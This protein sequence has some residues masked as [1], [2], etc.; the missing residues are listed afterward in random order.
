[1]EARLG[2]YTKRGGLLLILALVLLLRLPFLNQ[3]IQ[4]DD[5]IYRTEAEHAQ[6]DPL[7]PNDV[8]YVFLGDVVDLRGHSHPPLNAWV[9]AAL[10]AV[11]GDIREVPFHAGYIVFSLIAA[12]AMWSLAKRYSPEPLWATL[13]FCA[14]PAFVINGNSLESDLPFLA[15]WMSAVALFTAGRFGW[16]AVAMAAAAM[17]AY[18]AVFLIPILA[19]WTWLFR[20]RD[21]RAWLTLAAPL[22]TIAAWQ[23]YTR[24]TTG[25]LPA[26]MLA[27]YFSAYGFQAL[28]KKLR[29]ALMLFIHSWFIVFPLLS[30][31][32]A[33][34]AWRQRR[35]PQVHWLTAWIVLFYGGAVMVF[36]SGSA[37]YLLPMAAPVAL[38]ASRLPVKWV[39]T[40]F[41][42]QMAI[43]LG[44]AISNY[45]HWDGY[46]EFARE[47]RPA[48]QGR[49][50]WVDGEWGLRF[51]FEADGALPLTKTQRVKP[52]D[53]IVYADLMKPVDFT[54]PAA[55]LATREITASLPFRTIALDT[56]SG[57][58]SADKG[59]FPFG[60]STGPIDRVHAVLV[61]EQKPVTEYLMMNS[62]DAPLQIVSG[63]YA[64]EENRYRWM[65][66]TAVILLKPPPTPLP[67]R[68]TFTIPPN[69]PARTVRFLLDSKEIAART[70][71]APGTYTLESPPA[72]GGTLAIEI[73][74]TFRAPGDT[75][76]LGM[77]LTGAGFAR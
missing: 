75:R 62:P 24:A 54:A 20:R 37:R 48:T 67:V 55:P 31:G 28:E 43:A 3:A 7:H 71:P 14:V 72:T 57:F 10:L 35:D 38:L 74:R 59:F 9:L 8:K 6:I 29:S 73:D 4:G 46:R 13:L 12:M 76:D 41:A 50:V 21:R 39:T 33:A 58:S 56:A 23:L 42:L 77:V 11:T 16:A 40:G 17:T 18:Q 52:G 26:N 22:V 47:M 68:A 69:A 30:V 25:A 66:K 45:Q 60:L 65:S 19:V 64:L 1:M 63:V 61:T 49:R 51:Y 34:I 44:L 27:G 70:Y 15:A 36:F 32:A 53:V 5:D 2:S